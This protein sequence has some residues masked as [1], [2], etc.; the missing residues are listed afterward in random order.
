MPKIRL[1]IMY[2]IYRNQLIPVS[3]DE[4]EGGANVGNLATGDK[5]KAVSDQVASDCMT[6][7]K[8]NSSSGI[9]SRVIEKKNIRPSNK[10]A[11][12]NKVSFLRFL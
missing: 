6:S 4:E 2:E 9:E 10:F 11:L 8:M 12:K 5:R 1:Q 7:D 3:E